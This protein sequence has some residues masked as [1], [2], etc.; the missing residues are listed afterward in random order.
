MVAECRTSCWEA[1]L[2]DDILGKLLL[3]IKIIYNLGA[4]IVA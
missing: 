1:K 2:C 4:P 3:S